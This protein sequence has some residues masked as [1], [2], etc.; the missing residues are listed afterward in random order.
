LRGYTNRSIISLVN[1]YR[2]ALRRLDPLRGQAIQLLP[3]EGE[4][5][6][7]LM[8]SLACAAGENGMEILSCASELDLGDYGILPGKCIDD[9]Y[10]NSVFGLEV[11]HAK[12]PSQRKACGC[13]IS[14]DI[15]M[16]ESC[17]FGCLY[18][19]ATTSF[20]QAKRNYDA[21]DPHSPSLIGKHLED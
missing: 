20:E 16:Y 8:I 10:I 2:K 11:A 19:Y 5:L 14:K 12:D 21:H 9:V 13:V 6:A 17:L 1:P 7:S 15:G 3:F 18:C 4:T